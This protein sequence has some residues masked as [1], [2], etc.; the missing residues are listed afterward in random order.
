MRAAAVA[1][2]W[3]LAA[4]LRVQAA[5]VDVTNVLLVGD[6]MLG[7][8]VN[9]TL[10]TRPPAFPL[11]D[12]LPMFERADVAIANLECVI[13][14]KGTPWNKTPKVFHFRTDARNVVV[15]QTA[16]L[17]F[18]SV[19]NNHVLDYGYFALRDMLEILDHAGVRHAGAGANTAEACQP[20]YMD[21]RGTRVGFL[22]F[23]DN[24]PAWASKNDYP[25]IC[26]SRVD[27]ADPRAKSIL[28]RV[29]QTRREAGLVIVSAH[30]G[31][32]WGFEPPEEHTKF[33]RALIDAGADIVYG[34][35]SHIFRGIEVYKGKPILYSAGD[36][37]DDY[38][39]EQRNDQSFLYQIDATARGI[40]ELRLY[41]TVIQMFQARRA[42]GQ[43]AEQVAKRMATL[44]VPVKTVSTWDAKEGCLRIRV[45]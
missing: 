25:G 38:A 28:E 24:E 29:R 5:Q 3:M 11:G 1:S 18:V 21:V 43:L 37:V 41:P 8:L 20:A 22:A 16:S 27:T 31:G 10:K 26:Y 14:D 15:L 40:R 6:I 19:A 32:N 42:T 17:D 45:Q 39:V 36:F 7:R 35:S 4:F 13:A 12:T 2:V 9:E 44:S 33:A 34:H 23:T 30:W